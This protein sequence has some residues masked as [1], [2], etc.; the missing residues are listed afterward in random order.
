VPANPL[1]GLKVRVACP[2]PPVAP[3]AGEPRLGDPAALV[4][5]YSRGWE[6]RL[7]PSVEVQT[8]DPRGE[9]PAAADVW[10]VR[11][12]RLARWVTAGRLRPLPAEL[13]RRDA[14][15]AWTDL[16]P[17]DRELLLTWDRTAYAV[18]LLGEAPVCCYRKD[19]LEDAAARAAFR[20]QHDRD[21]GPPAS[22]EQFAQV[23]E[24]FTAR[25]GAPSLPP[26]PADD[27]ALDRLFYDVAAPYAR[28][29]VPVDEPQARSHAEEIFSFHYDLNTG[30]PRIDAP[31]F[32][33]ALELL[34]R[35][36]TCRPARPD[37]V[38]ER[39]FRDGKAV[40]CLTDAC[41]VAAFQHTPGL[42]DRVG[43]CRVPGSDRVF[44]YTTGRE[45]RVAEPNRVPYLGGAGWLAVVPQ[46]ATHPEVAFD[47]LGDLAGPQ[48][49]GQEVL[50][51][52]SGAGPV[53]ET[54]LRHERWDG[55]GL[56]P[57][58]SQQLQEVL[59]ETLLHRGI[60]N[61]VVCLRTPWEAGHRAA[62]DERLREA[63]GGKTEPAAALR[64][65][66]QRWAEMDRSAG[67]AKH[68]AEYRISL[69]L[70]PR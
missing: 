11:P 56:D 29:A 19:W 52:L 44:D 10:V 66:A 27:A 8:F 59:Q 4:R 32:A 33:H 24:F 49:S 7:G 14:P 48:T 38:P 9:P 3:Q 42:R 22:W 36:Q 39:A 54:Q 13:T 46:G 51:P 62:L 63:L 65:A 23:A 28:R 58:A 21:L 68:L 35:M 45:R 50:D 1:A 70:S 61:P 53:R 43:V 41:W 64:A 55:Y 60:K 18:P 15:F 20:R 25:S 40:L 2:A 69:G 6:S 34:R 17:V 57:A 37:A 47:L 26:L 30:R 5:A 31:G 67:V 12:A 16:L